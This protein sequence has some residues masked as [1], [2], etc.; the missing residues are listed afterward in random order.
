[1]VNALRGVDG[2]IAQQLCWSVQEQPILQHI[3]ITMPTGTVLGVLGPNGAGKT[4]LLKALA[5]QLRVS[6]EIKWQGEA[7]EALPPQSLARHIAVVN[8]LNDTVFALNLWQIVR[9]GLLPHQSLLSTDT[10]S[11]KQRI[12]NAIELVGL[13][14]KS[15]QT[16][17]TLSGGEQQRGLIARALVQKASL[18]VLDEPVNHLDVFYQHQILDLLHQLAV[19]L[20]KTVVVSLHDIN[21]AARYCDAICLM[22]RGEV[23]AQGA[24]NEVLQPAIL[25]SI[26]SMPCKRINTVSPPGFSIEFS[27]HSHASYRFGAFK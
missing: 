19:Q 10:H 21:L 9:M 11:D 3:N 6:G 15:E 25:E 27:P 8:Q 24:A 23:V 7:L 2:L 13:T 12:R 26:F 16:F 18:L 20:D 17:S 22:N 5:G 1:M 4:S 14:H